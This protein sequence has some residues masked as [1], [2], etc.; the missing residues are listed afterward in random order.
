MTH[1]HK[2]K[3]S[4]LTIST[5]REKIIKASLSGLTQSTKQPSA[6]E[7]STHYPKIKVSDPTTDTRGEKIIKA[8]HHW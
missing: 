4:N 7:H 2:I 3:T 6:V 5:R 8:S 1:Y